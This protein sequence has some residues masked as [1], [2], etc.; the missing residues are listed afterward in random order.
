M[1]DE[2]EKMKDSQVVKSR[3]RCC[4]VRRKDQNETTKRTSL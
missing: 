4:V 1:V 3:R 2:S